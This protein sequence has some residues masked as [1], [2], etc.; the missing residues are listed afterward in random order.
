MA[1]HF[2]LW[3]RW[4]LKNFRKGFYRQRFLDCAAMHPHPATVQENLRRPAQCDEDLLKCSERLHKTGHACSEVNNGKSSGDSL[5]HSTCN[6][7]SR[8]TMR[9]IGV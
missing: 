2:L 7:R 6:E 5:F 1:C 9:L 4:S 8:A 3:N